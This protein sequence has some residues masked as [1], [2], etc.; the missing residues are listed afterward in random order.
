MIAERE[1]VFERRVSGERD[2]AADRGAGLERVDADFG[3]TLAAWGTPSGP[4]LMLPIL[5]P[6]LGG[7]E[8]LITQ[9]AMTS[10][11]GLD[12]EARARAG[13]PPVDQTGGAV[14]PKGLP[15]AG[16]AVVA[17]SSPVVDDDLEARL[18]RTA[19]GEDAR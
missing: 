19:N 14:V 1:D 17:N 10:H 3:Q 8:T 16:A 7:P 5:G 13:E 6:S 4:Y 11:L 15:G 2:D 18:L 12:A 9:P